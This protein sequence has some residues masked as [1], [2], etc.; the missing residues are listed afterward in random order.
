M[1]PKILILDSDSSAGLESI[2]SLGRLGARIHAA[3][4]Q[5]CLA[6]RSRYVGEHMIHPVATDQLAAWIS[7]RHLDQN[8]DLIVP[9]TERALMAF[10]AAE[11]SQSARQRA[12]LAPPESIKLALDKEATRQLASKLGLLLPRSRMVT[13]SSAP[14]IAYPVVLKPVHS[15][16]VRAGI[17]S[18]YVV[19]I[20]RNLFE[21][22]SALTTTYSEI[23]VQE[24]EYVQGN[25]VGVEM[26]FN[27]G[28]PC[29]HFAHARLHEVPLT[30]GASS[31]RQSIPADRS[32]I[33]P[34]E[35]LLRALN[36]HGVA[37]VEFKRT[38][39]GDLFLVEINPRLWG[40]LAL[41]IDAGV[42]FPAGLL[43]LAAGAPLPPQPHYKVGYR[44][45]NAA[46]DFYWMR[47]N[48]L[49]D[50]SD[51]LLLTRPRV[52]SF[53]EYARPLLRRESW[54]F[55]D[56]SDLPITFHSLAEVAAEI[57]EKIAAKTL[58]PFRDFF[59]KRYLVS[60]QQK[61][62]LRALGQKRRNSILFLCYGNICRSPLA[63]ALARSYMPEVQVASA[64][65]HERES[66]IS[67]GF[68]HSVA[69]S[70]DT[71]LSAHRSRRVIAAMID[72]ADVVAIMDMRN[73]VQLKE[74]SPDALRKTIFLGMFAD[75]PQLEIEDPYGLPLEDG[76]R[77]GA[78]I[79]GSIQAMARWMRQ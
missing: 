17:V 65:F 15:K 24:Q 78:K 79:E 56:R 59:R 3:A 10:L 71:D 2:Q 69:A 13:T 62:V 18:S 57:T 52:R 60:I 5:P 23:D 37:M 73:Y 6:F 76:L 43:A 22:N 1:T 58:S 39:T 48:L 61:S 20:A 25:G 49:A 75:P 4:S 29:W 40:S 33:E 74:Q 47:A 8:Y 55:F 19:T 32:L 21:W 7:E 54:D 26:L 27:H 50:H 53:L 46:N 34:A 70:L 14:P 63:E 72:D 41:S 35:R 77:I 66:R 64:G 38:A 67:P 42:N 51:P 36:W 31:Y 12:V 68:M 44:T 9:V 45:R 11:I 16:R 28:E 30:G